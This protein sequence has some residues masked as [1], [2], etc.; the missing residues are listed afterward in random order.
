[1]TSGRNHLCIRFENFCCWL[2]SWH[3]PYW[4][5]GTHHL[6]RAWV[7]RGFSFRGCPVRSSSPLPLWS[8][9]GEQNFLIL[10]KSHVSV[11]SFKVCA[12]CSIIIFIILSFKAILPCLW[13]LKN[14]LYCRP[15]FQSVF[16]LTTLPLK[17]TFVPSVRW[18]SSSL[19]F[20]RRVICCSGIFYWKAC[21]ELEFHFSSMLNIHT[22]VHFCVRVLSLLSPCSCSV[23]VCSII[24]HHSWL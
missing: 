1:M 2:F 14:V 16:F 13:L 18:R 21:F 12:F 11:Y 22:C 8:I 24:L 4:F 15:T 9:W 20:S 19:F 7:F 6:F 17:K 5:V 23:R 10:T 3:L